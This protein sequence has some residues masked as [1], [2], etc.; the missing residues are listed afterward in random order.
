MAR[1]LIDATTCDWH[2]ALPDAARPIPATH[3]RTLES[4]DVDLCDSC[5]WVFDFYYPRRKEVHALLQPSVLDAFHRSARGKDAAR[6]QAAQLP[7]PSADQPEPAPTPKATLKAAA[8]T[9]GKRYLGV[10]KDDVVQVRCPLPHQRGTTR[11]YWVDLRN[12]TG[13]A[14]GHRKGDG[15]SYAGP[16]IAFELPPGEVFTHFCTEHQVCAENGG[17][18]FLTPESLAAHLHKSKD[19]APASKE[20]RDAAETRLQAPAA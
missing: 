20:A 1:E 5:T 4:G 18:G 10:W 3:E 14:R 16:D 6:R 8:G 19:W 12:R 11:K 7:I 17:Y 2:A 15:T 9:R 13:H